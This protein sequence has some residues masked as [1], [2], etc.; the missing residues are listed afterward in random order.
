[1]NKKNSFKLIAGLIVSATLAACSGQQEQSAPSVIVPSVSNDSVEVVEELTDSIVQRLFWSLPT[2][3][4]EENE[5]KENLCSFDAAALIRESKDLMDVESPLR[6]AYFASSIF[7]EICDRDVTTIDSVKIYNSNDST[8]A[9]VYASYCYVGYSN[10]R[11]YSHIVTTLSLIPSGGHW[12]IDDF[13]VGRD[14]FKAE[15]KQFIRD[16]RLCFRSTE[17]RRWFEKERFEG[18]YPRYKVKERDASRRMLADIDAYLEK[19]PDNISVA[20]EVEPSFV[21]ESSTEVQKRLLA[22]GLNEKRVRALFNAIPGRT[23]KDAT[24]N[25]S[26]PD[27][28]FSKQ[29]HALLTHAFAVPV[30]AFGREMRHEKLNYLV[31]GPE[32]DLVFISN[33]HVIPITDDYVSVYL[34]IANIKGFDISKSGMN[35]QLIRENGEWQL[36]DFGRSMSLIEYI[37]TQR[38]Y[39]RSDEWK[40][41]IQR[42][43]YLAANEEDDSHRKPWVAA[44]EKNVAAVEDYF[45]KYPDK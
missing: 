37:L 40:N 27:K 18:N 15:I 10:S 39:F 22:T 24:C 31:N 21:I 29:L 38:K 16:Q 41:L 25:L 12:L 8:F 28:A 5:K 14:R 42:Q 34:S 17:W 36:A 1:M 19:Y 9:K 32:D 35:M 26:N 23:C 6:T 44:I 30:D 11:E 7:G 20:G 43:L 3:K 13:A 33:A 45:L 2:F 4:G